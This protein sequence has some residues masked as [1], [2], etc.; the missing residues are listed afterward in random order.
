MNKLFLLL[1]LLFS[2]PQPSFAQDNLCHLTSTFETDECFIAYI[3]CSND[4]FVIK[5]IKDSSP[6]EQLLLVLDTL[7]CFIAESSAIPLNKVK[8]IPPN[9]PFPGKQVLELPATLHSLAPGVSTDKK[10]SYQDIDVHQRFRKENSP[11]WKR[12]GPLPKRKNR[13]NARSDPE[14]G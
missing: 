3:E 9:R 7:G 6:D 12:F 11:M 1:L 4:K 13:L 2:I 5:Q 8:I 14:Y 10:C